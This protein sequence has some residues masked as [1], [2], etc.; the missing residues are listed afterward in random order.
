MEVLLHVCAMSTYGTVQWRP[1]GECRL[2][3]GL[4]EH[5]AQVAIVLVRQQQDAK[6]PPELKTFLVRFT[7]TCSSSSLSFSGGVAN[8]PG[9]TSPHSHLGPNVRIYVYVVL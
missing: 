2:S 6:H 7:S 9:S 5:A 1:T 4:E 3:T 8:Q